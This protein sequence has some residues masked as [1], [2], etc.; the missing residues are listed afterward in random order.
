L[1]NAQVWNSNLIVD[2]IIGKADIS[3]DKLKENNDTEVDYTLDSGGSIQIKVHYPLTD[4]ETRALKVKLGKPSLLD[5]IFNEK[6]NRSEFQAAVSSWRN[7]GGPSPQHSPGTRT[8]QINARFTSAPAPAQA[9]VESIGES[10]FN[11]VGEALNGNLTGIA[12]GTGS[13]P[14]SEANVNANGTDQPTSEDT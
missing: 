12:N 9:T 4:Q 7:K 3:F 6:Q 1:Q 10:I 5:G 14:S 11:G 2:E 13:R 8:T